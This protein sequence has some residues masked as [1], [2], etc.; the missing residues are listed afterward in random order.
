MKKANFA[1]SFAL[2]VYVLLVGGVWA[3]CS[4][5]AQVLLPLP[6]KV[7]WIGTVLVGAQTGES[8]WKSRNGAENR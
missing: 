2:I 7:L 3:Y 5:K 1:L 8:V 6:E 4:I